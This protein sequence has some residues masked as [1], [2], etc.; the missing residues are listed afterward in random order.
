MA[1]IEKWFVEQSRAYL[2]SDYLPKIRISVDALSEDDVWWQ[3]NS[4]SNSIG[5]LLLHLAGNL[6]Q[7]IVSGLGSAS[8]ERQRHIEFAPDRKARAKELMD[9]LSRTVADADA[10]LANLDLS[11]L[12]DQLVIQGQSETGREALYHAV[13]HFSMHTGQIIYIAKLRSGRDLAFEVDLGIARPRWAERA[14]E[15]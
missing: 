10:V 8:D 1:N 11:I 4:T 12:Q 7:W 6:R 14:D 2:T 5:N 9:G 3:P 13:E 15:S